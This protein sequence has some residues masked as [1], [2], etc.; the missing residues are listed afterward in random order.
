[1]KWQK[2][3]HL[4]AQALNEVKISVL[5]IVLSRRS[6]AQD[7]WDDQSVLCFVTIQVVFVV[8]T[9]HIGYAEPDSAEQQHK[10]ML[11]TPRHTQHIQVWI[12]RKSISQVKFWVDEDCRLR[13]TYVV[14]HHR[15]M[16]LRGPIWKQLHYGSGNRVFKFTGSRSE[17]TSAKQG[18]RLALGDLLAKVAKCVSLNSQ[19]RKIHSKSTTSDK[20]K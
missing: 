18:N 3:I 17:L 9:L 5:I 2:C 11:H 14:S 13:C 7:Y 20:L 4:C 19:I 16:M 1:M 6:A 10:C 8:Q 12:S 15:N